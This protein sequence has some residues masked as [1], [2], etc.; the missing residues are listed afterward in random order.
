[1][2]KV[3]ECEFLWSAVEELD[4]LEF[5]EARNL[6][7]GYAGEAVQYLNCRWREIIALLDSE[8]STEKFT[9]MLKA[10][11]IAEFATAPAVLFSFQ[12]PAVSGTNY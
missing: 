1:L 6:L 7:T 3:R 2:E 9:R 11:G 12:A 5:T 10:S 8:R 4:D